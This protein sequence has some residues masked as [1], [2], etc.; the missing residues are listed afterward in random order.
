MDKSKTLDIKFDGKNY[1]FYGATLFKV[2]KNLKMD[3]K[4]P[5]SFDN[6]DGL[7]KWTTKNA[8][9]ISW[10]LHSIEPSVFYKSLSL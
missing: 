10:I 4:K 6:K 7:P 5:T 3:L 9:V 8:R 1:F 2:K